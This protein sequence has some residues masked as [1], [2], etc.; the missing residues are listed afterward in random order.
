MRPEDRDTIGQLARALETALSGLQ[1]A[2]IV[3]DPAGPNPVLDSRITGN[4]TP[5]M[6][7]STMRQLADAIE[8]R[9]GDTQEAH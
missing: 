4:M 3:T 7:V 9:Q 6:M 5:R 8:Q 2:L 1:F